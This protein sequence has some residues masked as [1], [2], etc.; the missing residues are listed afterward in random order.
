VRSLPAVH[1]I[2]QQVYVAIGQKS[3]FILPG[4]GPHESE[5][6]RAPATDDFRGDPKKGSTL[7]KDHHHQTADRRCFASVRCQIVGVDS[8]LTMLYCV[9]TKRLNEAAQRNWAKAPSE[10]MF[11][12]SVKDPGASRPELATSSVH[13]AGRSRGRWRD[14]PRVVT[15]HVARMV[16]TILNGTGAVQAQLLVVRDLAKRLAEVYAKT[17]AL[18]INDDTFSCNTRAQPERAFDALRER[19]TPPYATER[20]FGFINPADQGSKKTVGMAWL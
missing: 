20:P 8:A 6:R 7:A 15:E 3:P 9:Q 14:A 13:A 16:A 2:P 17:E 11:R 12:L 19:I 4:H 5:G 18:A 1:R 10:F